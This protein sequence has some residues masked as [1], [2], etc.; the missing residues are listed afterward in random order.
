M[1]LLLKFVVLAFLFFPD[2]LNIYVGG[3]VCDVISSDI[4]SIS[5]LT[6][7]VEYNSSALLYSD[8]IFHDNMRLYNTSRGYG[9]PGWWVKIWNYEDSIRGRVGMDE[10]VRSSFGWK[11][12]MFMSLYYQFGYK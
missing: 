5:C 7:A 2:N 9:S 3:I 10:Y 4:N 1:E 12:D 6:R 11:Q 8:D